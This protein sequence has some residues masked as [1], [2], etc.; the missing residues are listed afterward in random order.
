MPFAFLKRY[1]DSQYMIP[2]KR[3]VGVGIIGS[4]RIGRIHASNLCNLPDAD[5]IAI[6]DVVQESAARCAEACAIPNVYS[7]HREL[8][9][10][11]NIEAI[12]IC[13]RTQSHG[14]LIEEAAASGKH[15]FCEKPIALDLDAIDKALDA[16]ATAGVKLQIGFQRRF[17]PSFRRAYEMISA[18]EVGKLHLVRITSRDPEPPSLDYIRTSGG[19]FLDMTIHDFDMVRFLVPDEVA[20]IQAFGSVLMEPAIGAAGDIDTAVT[21][22][23]FT[24]G[25]LATIE[26]S[27]KCAYGY[28]QRVEVF[29][30]GGMIS[31]GNKAAVTTASSD[32]R[33]IH[34]PLPL[35]FFTERYADAYLEEMKSFLQAVILNREPE[36]TGMDGRIPVVMAHAALRSL[37]EH[38]PVHL[39]EIST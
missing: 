21:V 2:R 19:I 35:H 4:G 17:D 31:V 33:G 7:C 18:G 20:E 37:S 11:S 39:E 32:K 13:T 34:G 29:G 28:D 26:N 24:G 23:T 6:A 5:L 8:L 14:M 36:V 9:E 16:V 12:L 1:P 25:T 3:K 38:R 30:S 27:R 15:I 10:N 22:I